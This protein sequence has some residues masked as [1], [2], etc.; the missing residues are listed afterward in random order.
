MFS[1]GFRTKV[2]VP[3]RFTTWRSAVFIEPGDNLVLYT[4]LT[5]SSLAVP[6]SWAWSVNFDIVS[7]PGPSR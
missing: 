7:Y 2:Q 1:F 5:G 6:E 4:K 3:L